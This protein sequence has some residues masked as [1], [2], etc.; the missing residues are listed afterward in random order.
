MFT[1]SQPSGGLTLR[2]RRPK[3]HETCK[4]SRKALILPAAE[5][6][7]IF[8]NLPFGQL[9]C[10]F[11]D[12]P[13]TLGISRNQRLRFARAFVLPLAPYAGLSLLAQLPW[14]E[15]CKQYE[16]CPKASLS[17]GAFGSEPHPSTHPSL[18]CTREA[19][20]L[21]N[22]FRFLNGRVVLWESRLGKCDF[23]SGRRLFWF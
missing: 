11:V 4:E 23:S 7:C 18:F 8:P 22:V 13:P 6:L 14:Q 10:L 17:H 1:S 21:N 9:L 15:V 16:G 19:A 3:C 2:G 20:R 12:E 5:E